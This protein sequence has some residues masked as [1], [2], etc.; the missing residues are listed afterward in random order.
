MNMARFAIFTTCLRGAYKKKRDCSVGKTEVKAFWKTISDRAF[1]KTN[2]I[3][4]VRNP[5]YR[6]VL[7]ILSTT[8]VGRKSGKN[9]ANWIELFILMCRVQRREFNLATVLADSFSRGR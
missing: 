2:L 5:V 4:S 1:G 8:L 6:Y 7:K 3:T 9:K